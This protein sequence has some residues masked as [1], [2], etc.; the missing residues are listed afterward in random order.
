VLENRLDLLVVMPTGHGKLAA[1]MIPPMVTGRTIIVVVPLSILVNGHEADASRAGL[2]YATYGTDII[3][4]HDPLSILF[5]SVER[6]TTPRFVE[7][8]H[9]L[10]HLQKLHCVIVD[11]A[12]LLLSD[13]RPVMKRLL[14]LWVMGCQLVA[15][16]TSLSPSQETDLKIMMSMSLTVIRMSTVRPLIG[17]VI[18]EVV[19][20]DDEIIRQLVEWDCDVSSE[21]DWAIVY[22]LTR[23]FVKHVASIANNVACV[24]IA[25][26]HAHLDED[27]KKAQLQSWLSGEARVMVA[28]GVIGCGYNYPSVRLVIHHGSFRYF[29]ALHQESG[30]LA[31]DDKP[32]INRVISSAKSKAEALHIDSSFVQPNAWITDTENY[33]RH[34]F[35][36]AVDGQSQRCNLIP[37]AQLCDNCVRQS[38]AVSLEPPPPLPM[39][40]VRV[41][42]LTSFMNEDCTSLKNF[43]RFV[44]LDEPNCLMCSVYGDVRNLCHPS[45]NC[46]LLLDGCRCFKCLGSHPR[47]DCP[48][49]IPR[50]PDSCPKCHLLH[51]EQALGNVQLHEGRYG[52]DC[53]GQRYRIL[54]WAIWR[55]NPSDMHKAM[56]ELKDIIRDEE[57][58]RWMGLKALGRSITNFTQLVDACIQMLEQDNHRKIQF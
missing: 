9:T 56:P 49:S 29:T 43:H 21:T 37:T 39:L 47:S 27:A 10:N 1:F 55:R 28:T 16:T 8:A 46:P 20:V 5:V 36:L 34:N 23:Q 17:Y 19:D 42:V 40:R 12:H 6:A 15:L 48:N 3:T 54:L 57:L 24:K 26:L 18:D 4:F 30:R 13:F 11:E 44:A 7:L 45:Q 14:P 2:R 51:N 58:A 41:T 33:R 22:Y 32:N 25:H 52:V 31:R 50:S 38:R 35:H 53:L